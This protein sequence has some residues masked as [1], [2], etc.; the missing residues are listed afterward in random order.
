VNTARIRLTKVREVVDEGGGKWPRSFDLAN[1][2]L[3]RKRGEKEAGI[4][5]LHLYRGKK[6]TCRGGKIDA[7]L[8][9]PFLEEN[10]REGGGQSRAQLL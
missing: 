8:F 4:D 3:G 6:E 2:S 1:R 10:K 9:Q 7:S 5:F